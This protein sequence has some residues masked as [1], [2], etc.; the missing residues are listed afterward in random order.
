MGTPRRAPWAS[1]RLQQLPWQQSHKRVRRIKLRPLPP[2]LPQLHVAWSYEVRT[3]PAQTRYVL[4]AFCMYSLLSLFFIHY[5]L[6]CVTGWGNFLPRGLAS[7]KQRLTKP[8]WR[9]AKSL[10]QG[11]EACNSQQRTGGHVWGWWC[12]RPATPSQTP[13]PLVSQWSCKKKLNRGI[14]CICRCFTLMTIK[15]KRALI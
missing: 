10:D 13:V 5:V 7:T 3:P 1:L 9:D 6:M 11:Q 15:A 2:A 8:Q 12:S 14:G 4:P